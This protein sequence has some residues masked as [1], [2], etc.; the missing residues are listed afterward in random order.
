MTILLRHVESRDSIALQDIY[1]DPD[2]Y[3]GTLQTPYPTEDTWKRRIESLPE[4]S[5]SLVA[6]SDGKIIAHGAV[7]CAARSPRRKHVGQLGIV[8]HR[9]WRQQGVGSTLLAALID[10]AENWLNLSRIELDVY[11]DNA[12]A[13]ALYKKHNFQTEGTHPHYA[14]RNGEY[15][16]C[17]SM[18]RIRE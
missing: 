9:D 5:V 13:I 4:G 17:Y 2:A 1:S 11:T 12:P 3:G 7:I 8:V 14:F 6:E 15:V 10:T 16:D 18:A